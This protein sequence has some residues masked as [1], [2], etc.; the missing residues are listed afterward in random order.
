MSGQDKTSTVPAWGEACALDWTVGLPANP[1]KAGTAERPCNLQTDCSRQKQ[2][3]AQHGRQ[4]EL[5][6]CWTATR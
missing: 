5:R 3:A 2:T 6:A 1:C 4:G